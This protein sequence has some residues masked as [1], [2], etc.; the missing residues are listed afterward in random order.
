MR[1]ISL[2]IACLTSGCLA[3]FIPEYPPPASGPDGSS[4]S[5]L[6]PAAA[7]SQPAASDGGAGGAAVVGFAAVQAGLD[8]KG[9]TSAACHGGLQTPQ[10]KAQP[11]TL[12]DKLAS[13]M[14]FM[15]GCTQGKCVD[16]VTP[17]ASLV[18]QKP[19][20]GSALTHSGGKLFADFN[21]PVYTTWLAWIQAGAPY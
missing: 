20:A 9:C 4:P 18:L 2:L 12:P 19:L 6:A 3:W 10:L 14:A 21:D 13:Y 7:P 5:D 16:T 11:A 15:S 1:T 17:V 8:S